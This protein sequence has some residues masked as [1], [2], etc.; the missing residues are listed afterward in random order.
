MS[1]KWT[2]IENVNELY[3]HHYLDANFEGDLRKEILRRWNEQA[4]QGKGDPPDAALGQLHRKFFRMREN[5]RRESG[6][7]ARFELHAGF[8]SEL[9]F[10]L[11]YEPKPEHVY[12]DLGPLPLLAQVRRADG[13][14]Y[15]W[16]I[17]DLNDAVAGRKIDAALGEPEAGLSGATTS[18]CERI[19]PLDAALHAV[20][21]PAGAEHD[22]E[23]LALSLDELLTREVF[24]HKELL[25]FVL[26][27]GQ[28]EVV[29]DRTK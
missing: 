20:Q 27:C 10:G 7:A 26:L 6:E 29:L 1:P 18:P 13:K 8:H 3:T 16:C 5:L 17:P 28:T 9:L 19:D 24:G 4:A 2:S 21:L 11:G 15:V 23:Q 12:L 25:R 22:P 14:P